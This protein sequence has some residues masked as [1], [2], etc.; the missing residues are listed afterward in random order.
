MAANDNRLKGSQFGY[1][2]KGPPDLDTILA[3]QDRHAAAVLAGGLPPAILAKYNRMQDLLAKSS[4]KDNEAGTFKEIA[5]LS[6]ELMRI[7]HFKEDDVDWD[8]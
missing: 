7:L 8:N 2:G 4:D 5:A 1:Y 3:L 6:R